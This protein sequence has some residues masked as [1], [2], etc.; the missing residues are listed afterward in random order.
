MASLSHLT[1]NL[2]LIERSCRVLT[3]LDALT[4][5]FHNSCIGLVVTLLALS[6][7]PLAGCGQNAH[8]PN[9]S[10]AITITP[11][12]TSADPPPQQEANAEPA[13]DSQK[14]LR[15]TWDVVLIEGQKIGH[16]HETTR[17]IEVDGEKLLEIISQQNMTIKRSGQTVGQYIEITSVEKP[18][19]RVV[20]FTTKMVSGE[21]VLEI[22][23]TYGDGKMKLQT[24]TSG[25]TTTSAINWDPNWGGPFADRLSLE[26]KP[27]QP[28]EKRTLRALIAGTTEVGEIEL[29][30]I[31]RESAK[32]LDGQRELLKIE[33]VAR[34]SATIP[35]RIWADD[36]GEVLKTSIDT[37]LPTETYR[38]TKEN[39]LREADGDFDLGVSTLVK[40]EK[41]IERPH[42]TKKIVYLARL[43]RGDPSEKFANSPTQSVKRIDEHTAEITVRSLMPGELDS[44][45]FVNPPEPTD[46][47]GSPNNLIQSDDEL[48]VN[49]ANQIAANEKDDWAVARSFEK[50]V[51]NTVTSKSF[52]QAIASASDVARSK[53]GDCTE[54]AVLLAALC[55][56]REI[57]ARVAMGLVYYA[58]AQGFAYHM[59][60]E[61]WIND[62]WIPMDATLGR[63]GIGA[64]HLKVADS[65]LSSASPV[66]ALLPVID[67]IG[68]LELEII[69]VE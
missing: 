28:G 2:T 3:P 51:R 5:E 14:L 29:K 52:S 45:G 46:A 39:A 10:P 37:G 33:S 6:C 16:A 47:D 62:Q 53:E 44:P 60:N 41:P 1:R 48:I 68:Q 36:T 50:H 31:G 8:S 27:M 64:A 56:A 13:A 22:A 7:L 21:S 18:S 40:I 12:E 23:G 9:A 63:G 66:S 57:P 54:H 20:S 61:V 24:T 35:G 58:P 26:R 59:W 11:D 17:E 42:T 34:F 15:E 30:A 69:S 49:M 19:G 25:K 32:L 43:K 55:R 67:V 65:D 38:T 4:S